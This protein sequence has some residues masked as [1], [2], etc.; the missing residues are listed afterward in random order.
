MDIETRVGKWVTCVD[1]PWY[2]NLPHG[3]T[4]AYR[5]WKQRA[6][7]VWYQRHEWKH[8]DGSVDMDEWINGF[9]GWGASDKIVK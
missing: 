7:H 6:G 5:I 3:G 1:G 9:R 8:V 4:I 2:P